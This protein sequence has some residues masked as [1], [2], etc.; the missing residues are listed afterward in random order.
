MKVLH[1]LYQ[2]LPNISGSSIRSRDI[3]NN[4]LKI[5]VK[6]IVV[7]SPF[8]NPKTNGKSFEEIDGIKYYRTFS[9]KNELVNEN[10]ASLFLQIKKFFRVISFSI[11]VYS[12]AKKEKI[13]V[14]HAHAMFFCAI[15]G[16]IT[17]I[18]LNKPLIYEVRSLWE[19]RFKRTSFLNYIIF[20]FSTFLETFCMFL[21]DHL[22]AINQNLKIELQNRLILKKRKITVV[23]NAVDFDR[24]ITSKNTRSELVFGYIGT[25][26][27]IEGLNLLIEAF[28]NLNLPNKLL[29]FGDGIQLENLKKLSASNSNII[30]QGKISSSEILK[31]YNQIDIIVNP[32]KSSY[33]TNSVTPLKTI[34]AMAHKKL[35]IA[36]DVG[37]MKE[38]IK[39]DQTGILFKSGDLFELEKALLKVLETNDLNSFIDNAYDY[40]YKQRNWYHNAKLYKKLYS[41][42]KNGK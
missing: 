3:L 26:S 41:K 11:K 35:V 15:A 6:P 16:K 17:S 38:L 37:G 42:L 28:N 22:I 1:I 40:I 21:A 20:S 25:L 19:E 4:Q 9:N 18:I 24:I 31:A 12:I 14:I 23:E 30:F 27:P 10:K 39:D 32:R 8:Q 34:E 13:D 5:G 7:T 2:S 36:S 33:L 29:I